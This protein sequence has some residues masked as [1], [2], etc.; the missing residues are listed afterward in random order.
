MFLAFIPSSESILWDVLVDVEVEKPVI[1]PEETPII[2]GS[3][4]D[5]AGDP[6]S[7]AEV[8]IRMGPQTT[9]I[10]TNSTGDFYH[11]AIGMPMYP[12]IHIVNFLITSTEGKTGMTSIDFRVS[13]DIEV[14]SDTAKILQTQEAVKYLHASPD[15]FE[16][17]PIGLTLYNY[18]QEMQE[19]FFEEVKEQEKI[20]QDLL[21]L[22]ELRSV[23]DDLEQQIIEEKSPGAGIYAGWKYDKFV[24]NLDPSVKDLIVN[25]LNH[26][27]TNFQEARQIMDEVLANGGTL[28]EARQAYLDKV[29][30]SRETMDKMTTFETFNA[31]PEIQ[32]ILENTTSAQPMQNS[33]TTS[34]PKSEELEFEIDG[35]SISVGSSGTTIFLNINGTIIEFFVNGTQITQITNSSSN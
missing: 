16:K 26:T 5:H 31:E 29:A 21:H 13:G 2:F 33:T 32:E 7:D 1:S 17:D 22:E 3:A 19:K 8:Q 6:L 23:S 12:G 4:Y 10:Y 35:T 18:Y 28:E 14:Y 11:E 24:S 30:V 15:N 25:Q 27:T 34:E 9:I 20:E